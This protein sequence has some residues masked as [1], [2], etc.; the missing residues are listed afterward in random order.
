M[1][2]AALDVDDAIALLERMPDAAPAAVDTS[3]QTDA[4]DPEELS[5]WVT[6]DA[7]AEDADDQSVEPGAAVSPDEPSDAVPDDIAGRRRHLDCTHRHHRAHRTGDRDGDRHD[8][9]SAQADAERASEA[10]LRRWRAVATRALA[11]PLA[12]IVS[13]DPH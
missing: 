4:Y 6:T 11:Q 5:L 9:Q 3:M 13:R 12:T 7:D 10:A 2:D 8:D 1:T